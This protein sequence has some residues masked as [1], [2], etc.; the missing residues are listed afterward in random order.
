[1]G[2]GSNMVGNCGVVD[3]GCSIMGW[4]GSIVGWGGVCNWSN[5]LDNWS[6]DDWSNYLSMDMWG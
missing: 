4:A 5:C 3:W 2:W 1:M 6:M